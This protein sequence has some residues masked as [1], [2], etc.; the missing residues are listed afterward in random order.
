MTQSSLAMDVGCTVGTLNKI[1][2]GRIKPGA[3]MVKSIAHALGRVLP[4]DDEVLQEYSQ[5]TGLGVDVLRP[6]PISG[7]FGS[8]NTQAAEMIPLVARAITRVGIAHVE[9]IL[10]VLAEPNLF[11]ELLKEHQLQLSKQAAAAVPEAAS[12][13]LVAAKLHGDR[14]VRIYDKPEPKAQ[15]SQPVQRRRTA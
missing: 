10:R 14:I 12:P 3:E 5:V 6:S 13:S 15:K 4:I 8:H 7:G 2:R 9:S 11:L 1:E